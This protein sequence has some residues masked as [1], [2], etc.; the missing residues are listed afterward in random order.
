MGYATI[1]GLDL[2]KFKSVF[3]TELEKGTSLISRK[4]PVS[5]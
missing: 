2:G 4:D 3:A 5:K 1:L